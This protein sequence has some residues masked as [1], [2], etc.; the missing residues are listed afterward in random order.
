MPSGTNGVRYGAAAK[1]KAEA[2]APASHISNC[3]TAR[4]DLP[5]AG[6][7]H[8]AALAP[9]WVPRVAH[10]AA[11]EPSRAADSADGF[12]SSVDPAGDSDLAGRSCAYPA[13]DS[14]WAGRS[15]ACPVA[16]S[17]S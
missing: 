6:H 16:D 4:D 11:D 5:V 15:Y 12:R 1:T 17:D 10:S 8:A 13:G 2:F 3:T 14:D 9:V 7:C